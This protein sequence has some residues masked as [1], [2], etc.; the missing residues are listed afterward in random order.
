MGRSERHESTVAG[1]RGSNRGAASRS[2]GRLNGPSFLRGNLGPGP[3][4]PGQGDRVVREKMREVLVSER[5]PAGTSRELHHPDRVADA[6][7]N[8]LVSAAS[9]ETRDPSADRP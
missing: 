2:P 6:R 5:G 3:P 1:G 7:G 9:L 4:E 8:R